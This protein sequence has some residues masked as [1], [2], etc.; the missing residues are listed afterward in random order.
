MTRQQFLRRILRRAEKSRREMTQIMIDSEW[1]RANRDP[2]IP[3]HRDLA[4]TIAGLDRLIATAR[5]M[6]AGNLSIYTRLPEVMIPT[7]EP[8]C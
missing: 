5:D 6:L 8:S 4:V 1:F 2:S 3:T 7:E